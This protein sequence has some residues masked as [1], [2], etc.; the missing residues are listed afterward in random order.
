MLA[1]AQVPVRLIMFIGRFMMSANDLHQRNM[2]ID[3][4]CAHSLSRRSW[5]TTT[6]SPRSSRPSRDCPISSSSFG[7]SSHGSFSYSHATLSFFV[8][9]LGS[10]S[11]RLDICIQSRFLSNSVLGN[12][13]ETETVLQERRMYGVKG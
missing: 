6:N 11:H 9:S 13:Y 10:P 3:S 12:T 5:L 2:D 8:I 7:S 1:Y 4:K